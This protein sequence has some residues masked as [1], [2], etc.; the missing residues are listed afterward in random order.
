M[1]NIYPKNSK[2]CIIDCL[3][4]YTSR[5][6]LVRGNLDGNPQG[7]ILSYAY[8]FKP[9]NSQS[10]ARYIKLFLAVAEID[11]TVFTTNSVCSTSTNKA[12]NIGLSIKDIQKAAGWKGNSKF[13][14]H[15][16]LPII[17]KWR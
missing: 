3:Q 11:I 10:I 2:L 6:D 13:R 5:T 7:L 9:M 12:N 8:P 16:K 4:E 14:K 15:Y 17:K 1:F